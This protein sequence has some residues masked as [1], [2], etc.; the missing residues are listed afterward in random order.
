MM[1]GLYGLQDDFDANNLP[2]LAKS[3]LAELIE[4]CKSEFEARFGSE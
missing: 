2:D 1:N 4:V 3:L